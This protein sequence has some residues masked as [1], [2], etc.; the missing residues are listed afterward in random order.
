MVERPAGSPPGHAQPSPGQ[1][2]PPAAVGTR[3]LRDRFMLA[4]LALVGA[5]AAV[6]AGLL[7]W[8]RVQTLE[9]GERLTRALATVIDEQTSR[10]LQAVDQQLVLLSR[11]MDPLGAEGLAQPRRESA[12][13]RGQVGALGFI[14]SLLVIDA[15]GKVVH[16][17]QRAQLGADLADREYVVALRARPG[18]GLFVAAPV[19]DAAGRWLLPMARP[20]TLERHGFDGLLVAL[21]QLDYFDRL[22]SQLAL[23][24]GSVVALLRSDGQL[25]M[26]SPLEAQAMGRSFANAPLFLQYLPNQAHGGYRIE[27]SID[28]GDRYIAYRTLA[29]HP[30]LLVTVG[31]PI[32]A[33]LAPWHTLARLAGGIWL[34]GALALLAFAHWL[35]R[36]SQ[37]RLRAERDS[38]ALAQRLHLASDATGLVLW[39]WDLRTDQCHVTPNYYTTLGYPVRPGPLSRPQWLELMHPDELEALRNTPALLD[40]QTDR[41]HHREMR[42]RHAD[43]SYRWIHTIAQVKDRDAQ[44]RAVRMVGIRLDVTERVRAE[45]DHRQLMDRIP[46]AL[47]GIGADWTIT[48]VNAKAT[49]LLGHPA[50]ELV[51]RNLWSTF[52]DAAGHPLRT[53]YEHC[54]ATQTAER[55]EAHFAP[56]DTWYESHA[57][58]S[59]EGLSVFLR[60][61]T[62]HKRT[63]AALR[64]AKEQA[65]NLING[66][67]LMVVGLDAQG[68]VTLFNKAA[69]ALTGYAPADLA[70]RNWLEV[71][72]PEHRYPGAHGEFSRLAAGGAPG[73]FENPI[74]TRSGEERLIS[75]QNSPLRDGEQ[76]T[77][78]LSFGID[79]TARRE[80]Q[81]RL[82]ESKEQFETLAQQSLQGIALVRKAHVV[83]ANPAFCTITRRS[84]DELS[85]RSTQ[86]MLAWIH[87]EDRPATLERQQLAREGQPRPH[88]AE[89]RILDGQGQW[90]WIQ[91]AVRDIVLSG[92]PALLLM[93]LDVHERHLAESALR[94]SELRFRHAF[95]SAGIGMALTGL[96]GRFLQANAA[97]CRMLGYSSQELSQRSF[98][99]VT[100]PDDQER[101]LALTQ[102]LRA[103]R[104][105]HFT[106]EKRYLHR[107]GHAVRGRLTVAMVRD[108]AGAPLQ[109][110]AQVED[111]DR[112]PPAAVSPPH[113]PGAI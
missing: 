25:L 26:R 22:W 1:A 16:A 83:Y 106:L 5:T 60:D 32:D 105:S 59:P 81:R 100:H 95:D 88:S 75:W 58:P 34:L 89:L 104:I 51:G 49:E 69:Q 86:Q 103:G 47:I 96:D 107:A 11:S 23:D 2:T 21:A 110:V 101:D 97:L 65:E 99:D 45:R 61:I 54:M 7:A 19:R 74:L 80:A 64:H 56:T 98:I 38:A 92:A 39:D 40:L 10:S 108:D 113:T 18:S 17:S 36:Q 3:W 67:N 109:W 46:D 15:A 27:S 6:V 29:Q 70:G 57:Y 37:Q 14:D 85:S 90:R 4:A 112:H 93:A 31:R 76:V 84:V 28:G 68:R 35:A 13:L 102:E 71:L 43:G 9:A 42:M 94:A 63:E 55:F 52:P 72:V 8:Q 91:L 44:G 77:G 66:A 111:L 41:R 48:H 24:A 12:L 79:V 62:D 33:L 73:Q 50:A 20:L 30:S 82:A 87:P 53:V 78:V